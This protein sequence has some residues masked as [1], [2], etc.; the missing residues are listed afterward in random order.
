MRLT[1]IRALASHSNL[2]EIA[3]DHEVLGVIGADELLDLG[4]VLNMELDDPTY[5]RLKSSI[6]Y[7]YYYRQALQYVSQRLRSQ[8]ELRNYLRK[9]GCDQENNA[10]IIEALAHLGLVDDQKLSAAFIHDALLTR[11]LSRKLIEQKLRQKQVDEEIISLQLKNYDD[12]S[13]LNQLI[14]KKSQLSAYRGK[15]VKFFRYL[16]SQGFDYQSIAA[17][18]GPPSN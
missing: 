12:E 4:L 16:L 3:I 10:K 18:I 15:Q 13:A 8:G 5:I 9:K 17:K 7:G 11:P 2:Y 14:A 1:N 6:G